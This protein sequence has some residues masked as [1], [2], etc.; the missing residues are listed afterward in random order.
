MKVGFLQFKPNLLDIEANLKRIE[1]FIGN[2]KADLIVLPELATTGYLFCDKEEVK[3]VSVDAK[4]S[5]TTQFFKNLS[6][7]KNCSYVVGIAEKAS[8][9]NLYNS[10]ILVNPNGEVF[11][12]RKTHLF[13]EEKLWFTPGDT[14]FNVFSIKNGVKIGMMICF[15]WMF[16]E[17]ARSLALKGAH[18]IAHP[19]NLVLPWCQKAMF[20]RSLENRVFSITANRIGTEKR[21]DKQLSFTGKSQIL[22]TIGSILANATENEETVKLIDI[23]PF[24]A[25]NKD[26]NEYNNIFQD[27]RVD[28]YF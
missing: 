12:Y 27:R 17:S 6:K 11:I 9:G 4:N 3:K 22:S 8:N 2:I 10:S 13:F 23:N 1:K 26:I 25:E 15:D 7:R 14:G 28:L 16:P 21:C 19:S 5:E 24:E 18:I 20:A